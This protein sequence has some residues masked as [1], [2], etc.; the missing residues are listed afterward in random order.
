MLALGPSRSAKIENG[1]RVVPM[2]G[3]VSKGV[4][5]GRTEVHPVIEVEV[6][7]DV[8]VVGELV[9]VVEGV[10][11][12]TPG[13]RFLRREPML[14]TC[15]VAAD[16][17]FGNVGIAVAGGVGPTRVVDSNFEAGEEYLMDAARRSS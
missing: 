10:H 1:G 7:V 3:T 9:F 11:E 16:Q 8:L 17:G 6:V 15:D 2:A 14:R 12:P 4:P 5:V 13:V